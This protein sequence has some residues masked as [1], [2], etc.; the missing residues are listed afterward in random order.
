MRRRTLILS[1]VLIAAA[2]PAAIAC[3]AGD[4]L[5][6]GRQ[7]GNGGE[8]TTGGS[9]GIG[10]V[11]GS[12]AGGSSA[13]AGSGIVVP[14]GGSSEQD[15]EACLEQ[16]SDGERLPMDMFIAYDTSGSMNDQVAGSTRMDVVR[17]AL[18]DFL[19]DPESAGIGVGIDYFPEVDP[20]APTSCTT[21][22]DCN[23]AT[24]NYGNCL[25]L[26][27]FV[28]L[29]GCPF[30][31]C[32]C[33]GGDVCSVSVYSDPAVPITLPPDPAPVI[34]SL[35]AKTTGGFT[36]LRWALEG[37]HTYAA[38]WAA[39]HP[40]RKVVVVLVGDGEPQGCTANT[41]ADAENVARAAVSGHNIATFVVGVGD[42]LDNLNRVAAAG[43]TGQAY[44]M[45]DAEAGTKLKQAMDDIRGRAFPC[46]IGLPDDSTL[47]PEKI[48]V[49]F[50][51]VGTTDPRRVPRTFNGQEDGCAGGEGWYYD[52]PV[53]PT[54][55]I[56]CP[57]TCDILT[58]GGGR[59]MTMQVGCAT[60]VLPPPR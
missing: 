52:D 26:I 54:Q 7:Q 56:M 21:N 8:S 32:A 39:E 36:P 47:D 11:S 10:A 14:D 29:V 40:E 23:T 4:S 31:P 6:P 53:N 58:S 37:A 38:S 5:T 43:G 2:T 22:A 45:S 13:T 3:A 18:I 28:N 27:P 44:L 30:Q 60:E 51:P 17:N 1:G 59:Q 33:T 12:S 19:N 20:N 35:R 46:A 25:S 16:Q 50:V 41:I 34:A 42:S 57:A 15:A 48:N 49:A 55:I 9:G 24:G